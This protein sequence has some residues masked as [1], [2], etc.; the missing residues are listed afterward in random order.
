MQ[1]DVFVGRF[2]PCYAINICT[3][4]KGLTQLSIRF[5]LR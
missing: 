2:F 5:E 1:L 4:L 3:T